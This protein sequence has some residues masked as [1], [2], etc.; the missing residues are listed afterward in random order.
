MEGKLDIL[1]ALVRGAG[2]GATMLEG[3]SEGNPGSIEEAA[4]PMAPAKTDRVDAGFL[5]SP[6]SL[7]SDTLLLVVL[8]VMSPRALLLLIMVSTGGLDGGLRE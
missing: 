7:D 1:G 3:R 5:L 2:A 6:C 8:L 4:R